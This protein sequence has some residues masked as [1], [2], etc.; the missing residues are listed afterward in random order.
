M[1]TIDINGDY[2]IPETGYYEHEITYIVGPNE[3][4]IKVVIERANTMI[5]FKKA[6]N[7][8]AEAVYYKLNNGETSILLAYNLK[9]GQNY[10]IKLEFDSVDNNEEV[11]D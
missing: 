11:E 6:K 5:K 9:S 1:N 3:N 10:T 7:A 8:L 2:M 4:M